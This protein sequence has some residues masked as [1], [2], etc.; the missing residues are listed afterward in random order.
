M[1][2][3]VVV[4]GAAASDS[5]IAKPVPDGVDG[6]LQ[7]FVSISEQLHLRCRGETRDTHAKQPQRGTG[8]SLEP[9]I[10]KF[11][12]NPL[13]SPGVRA[14]RMDPAL[15]CERFEIRTAD[16]DKHGANLKPLPADPD[17]RPLGETGQ[18]GMEF[19]ALVDVPVESFLCA[20]ASVGMMG[21][22]GTVIDAPGFFAHAAG[23]TPENSL[24]DRV[25]GKPEV[26]DGADA[27]V[28]KPG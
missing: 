15:S 18:P 12:G 22:Q 3:S 2:R 11:P 4:D 7:I 28:L 20:Y 25:G 14:G 1:Y 21:G 16:F 26:L 5:A 24:H 10:K 27:K 9:V 6:L 8:I 17:R 23:I 13:E 19:G